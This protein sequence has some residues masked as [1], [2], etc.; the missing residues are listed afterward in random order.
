MIKGAGKGC[1]TVRERHSPGDVSP[2]TESGSQRRPGSGSK[3]HF[4]PDRSRAQN[5]VSGTRTAPKPGT[6]PGQESEP[7]PGAFDVER[8]EKAGA[9]RNHARRVLHEPRLYQH[10]RNACC[11]FCAPH[12]LDHRRMTLLSVSA[13]AFAGL[14]GD[15]RGPV[16]GLHAEPNPRRAATAGCSHVIPV[17]CGKETG[18]QRHS[19]GKPS[20][21]GTGPQTRRTPR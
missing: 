17:G 6:S 13:V 16:A 10:C 9:S 5:L 7:W 14:P 21:S 8:L 2:D 4:H 20:E 19:P 12:S 1:R 11:I 18:G 15:S 3:K